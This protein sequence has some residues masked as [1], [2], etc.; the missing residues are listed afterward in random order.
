[1]VSS[2]VTAGRAER[3][4]APARVPIGRTPAAGGNT[5]ERH[6][7]KKISIKYCVQ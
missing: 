5:E 1:M 2:Y 4:V 3:Q 6:T 7:V